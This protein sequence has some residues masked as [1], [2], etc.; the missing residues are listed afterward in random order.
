MSTGSD[1]KPITLCQFQSRTLPR[2]P[3]ANHTEGFSARQV[4]LRGHHR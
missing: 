2:A 1:Q 3:R 4:Q